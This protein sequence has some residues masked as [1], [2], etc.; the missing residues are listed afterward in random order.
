MEE[1]KKENKKKRSNDT[2]QNKYI[3][4]I[5][6]FLATYLSALACV[7]RLDLDPW[8]SEKHADVKT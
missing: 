2:I 3:N 6:S 4:S 5:Y 1:G 7:P 8:E